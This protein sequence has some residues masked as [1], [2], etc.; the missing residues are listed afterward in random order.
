MKIVELGTQNVKKIS[1]PKKK[2]LSITVT[3]SFLIFYTMLTLV[4]I[5][6]VFTNS[7]RESGEILT[8][9]RIIPT[10]FDLSNYIKLFEATNIL[11]AFYNSLSIT[12]I[13]LLV[14]MVIVL[15]LSFAISR[16]K[17]RMA[18]YIYLFFSLAVLIPTITIL[19]MNYKLFNE[20][21]LLGYKYS[22]VIAYV[23]EQ[24]PISV[25]LMAMF[26]KAIPSELDEAAII[27]GCGVWK[28]FTKVTIPLSQNGIVTML[29]LA[30]VAIWNDY[31]TALIMIPKEEHK[32]LSVILAYAKG[33]YFVDYG[34]M[35]A[36][37]IFAI[38]P[39]LV[40]YL[41]TKEKLVSGMSLGAVKG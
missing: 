34:M 8:N 16:F 6:W 39:M 25:F 40:F 31:T 1:L 19:P 15:P 41:I 20:L 22:I 38:I 10:S 17:F 7:F 21:G 35:S 18:T 36:A 26:M 13:S 14:L 32:T 28:I 24:I 29:I 37:V 9:F 5:F 4:P 12:V 3:Y 27:D 30:S 11:R 23:V 33:E 2:H